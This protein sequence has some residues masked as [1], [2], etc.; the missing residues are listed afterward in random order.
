MMAGV[1]DFMKAAGFY[2]EITYAV[3]ASYVSFGIEQKAP[4]FQYQ[5]LY[6]L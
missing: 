2:T 6:L 3:E 4:E 1:V 5:G